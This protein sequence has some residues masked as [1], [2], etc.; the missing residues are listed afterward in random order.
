MLM[1][2][3]FSKIARGELLSQSEQMEFVQFG[4]S[5]QRLVMLSDTRENSDKVTRFESLGVR[6]LV[7][8]GAS[9]LSLFSIDKAYHISDTMIAN[10][11]STPVTFNHNGFG[12]NEFFQ[13]DAAGQKVFIRTP[14]RAFQIIVT[15][16][17]DANAAGARDIRVEF[18][19]ASNVSLGEFP[20]IICGGFAAADSWDGATRA[21]DLPDGTDY[22]KINVLQTSGGNLN[23][24]YLAIDLTIV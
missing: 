20:V 18:F 17:W 10:N 22:I 23:L 9:I 16:A 12:N 14:Y 11:T 4:D 15:H 5:L 24:N 6:R 21:V 3:I 8:Q 1:Q 2:D 19:D 13:L 7:P